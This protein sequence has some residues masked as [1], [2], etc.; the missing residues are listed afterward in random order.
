MEVKHIGFQLNPSARGVQ[1]TDE[2]REKL[3][4]TLQQLK[5]LRGWGQ[6]AKG[7]VHGQGQ[8]QLGCALKGAAQ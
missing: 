6:F 5:G 1:R 8:S 7:V 3:A 2:R 4:P